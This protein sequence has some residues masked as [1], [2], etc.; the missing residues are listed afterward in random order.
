MMIPVTRV[1]GPIPWDRVCRIDQF[2]T[3]IPID[4]A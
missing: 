2:G 1:V 4:L 3:E